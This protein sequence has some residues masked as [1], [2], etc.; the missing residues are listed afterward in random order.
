MILPTSKLTIRPAM[1]MSTIH[2]P[3]EGVPNSLIHPEND[4]AVRG[5]SIH[6]GSLRAMLAFAP[7]A[8]ASNVLTGVLPEGIRTALLTAGQEQLD[9]DAIRDAKRLAPRGQFDKNAV[10]AWVSVRS[11]R[12][13]AILSGILPVQRPTRSFPPE[14]HTDLA[15]R[16][17]ALEQIIEILGKP[18][19]HVVMGHFGFYQWEPET[20]S[21]LYDAYYTLLGG[22]GRG[23]EPWGLRTYYDKATATTLA[24]Y[25]SSNGIPAQIS[26]GDGQSGYTVV[27][28]IP[29]LADACLG[30][31]VNGTM[32]DDLPAIFRVV[33]DGLVEA[34]ALLRALQS[35][36]PPASS[37]EIYASLAEAIS[38]MNEEYLGKYQT[39]V[40]KYTEF[41]DDVNSAMGAMSES[42]SV[43]DEGD[44][45]LSYNLRDVLQT[46]RDK[47][48]KNDVLLSGLTPDDAQSWAQLLGPLA[49]AE[50]ST[51]KINL[52]PL[53]KLLE[54]TKKNSGK[55]MSP[56][57]FAAFQSALQIHQEKLQTNMQTL[58]Q[59][60]ST[61]NSTFDNLIKVLSSTIASLLESDKGFLQ[62]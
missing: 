33:A 51:V 20:L 24:E 8:N 22:S 15:N 27:V 13:S 52:E 3:T 47:W 61:A 55:Y 42:I 28:N 36:H 32:S 60:Y 18:Q 38:V 30:P 50:G 4:D 16:I 56:Q 34:E 57:K 46:T 35:L 1:Q 6:P 58:I 5:A 54:L 23:G 17:S 40:M 48:A 53:D 37:W 2:W 11:H 10:D 14:A 19:D 9:M 12:M 43:D 39:A 31:M 26:T 29:G 49:Y 7:L 41:F 44:V 21:L 62:I 59:K 25:L 45:Y